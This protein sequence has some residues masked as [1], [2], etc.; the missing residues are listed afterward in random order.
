[1]SFISWLRNRTSKRSRRW[2]GF[3]IRPTAPRFRPQLQAL[4]DR[5]LPTPLKVTNTYDSGPSSLRYEIAQATG[6][7]N[8]IV[9][10]KSLLGRTINLY[11]ELKISTGLTIQGPGAGLLT[12]TTN[13]NWGDP[14]GQ[15]TRVFEV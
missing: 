10:D 2:D 13:Y 1:M 8:T 3:Q 15:S 9:F 14:W 7:N 11:S 6:K 12:L 4:E 5:C